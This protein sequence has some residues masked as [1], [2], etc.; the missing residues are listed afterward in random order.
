M[1]WV[2]Q[3]GTRRWSWGAQE[4]RFCCWRVKRTRSWKSRASEARINWH[5]VSGHQEQYSFLICVCW[6]AQESLHEIYGGN[7]KIIWGNRATRGR[8]TLGGQ[9]SILAWQAHCFSSQQ[10]IQTGHLLEPDVPRGSRR[11]LQHSMLRL[12]A[13][14]VLRALLPQEDTVDLPPWLTRDPHRLSRKVRVG[15]R[16][17]PG[18]DYRAHT[19]TA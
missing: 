16:W 14:G 7:Q 6:T 12:G 10:A 2:G 9:L 15:E 4:S 5:T 17:R 18:A 19:Q 8:Q 13:G 3:S 1:L 11:A